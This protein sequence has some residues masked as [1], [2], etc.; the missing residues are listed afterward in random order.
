MI[1]EMHI[2]IYSDDTTELQLLHSALQIVTILS[3]ENTISVAMHANILIGSV[4]SSILY[5]YR[6]NPITLS[7]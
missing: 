6:I 2:Y 7:T 3:L 4:D 1:Y 5:F